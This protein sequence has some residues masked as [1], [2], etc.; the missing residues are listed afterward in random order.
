MQSFLHWCLFVLRSA[1]QIRSAFPGF[2]LKCFD[3]QPR[4][5][6]LSGC[7]FLKVVIHV[8]H[9]AQEKSSKLLGSCHQLTTMLPLASRCNAHMSCGAG[10][11]QCCEKYRCSSIALS[12]GASTF[13]YLENRSEKPTLSIVF[14]MLCRRC[15]ELLTCRSDVE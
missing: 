2:R 1:E 3:A 5:I 10:P 9:L 4:V 15:R 12:R 13:G 11:G 6:S 14:I 8:L 7:R